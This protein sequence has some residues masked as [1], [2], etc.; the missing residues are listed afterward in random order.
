MIKGLSIQWKSDNV[1]VKYA[2]V[3]KKSVTEFE[4]AV[5]DVVEKIAKIDEYL[6]ELRASEL[7]REVM[8]EIIEKI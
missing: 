7:D 3:L 2:K 5:N 8:A 1:V 6:E 4:E